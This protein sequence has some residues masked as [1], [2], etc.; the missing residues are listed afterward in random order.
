MEFNIKFAAM[1]VM[2]KFVGYLY[3]PP[4]YITQVKCVFVQAGGEMSS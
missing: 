4:E 1:E 3:V 2:L